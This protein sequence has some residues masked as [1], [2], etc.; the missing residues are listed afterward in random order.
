MAHTLSGLKRIRQNEKR[1]LYNRGIKSG[2]KAV[3]KKVQK[4]VVS[5]DASQKGPVQKEL[6]RAYQKLDKAVSSGVI[7]KNKAARLK[8][9]LTI[10][11]NKLSNK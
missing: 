6:V 10:A 2:V 4:L 8:S 1:R 9:R 3:V 5:A 7:H 11:V